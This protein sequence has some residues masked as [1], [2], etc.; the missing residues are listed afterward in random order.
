MWLERRPSGRKERMEVLPSL[1]IPE[2]LPLRGVDQTTL[3]K[4]LEAGTS[5]MHSP[6][7]E[8]VTTVRK[9]FDEETIMDGSEI[10]QLTPVIP[11]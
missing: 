9:S 8:L 2:I 7:L 6:V 1:S 3:V 11:L 10:L 4:V 5:R